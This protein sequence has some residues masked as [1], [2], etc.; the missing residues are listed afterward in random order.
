MKLFTITLMNSAEETAEQLLK[1][2]E[3]CIV[4]LH[5]NL[6]SV[7][8]DKVNLKGCTQITVL[9]VLPL[10]QLGGRTDD[11][12]R[13]AAECVAEMIVKEQE[14]SLMEGLISSKYGFDQA[15][16]QTAIMAY[17]RQMLQGDQ[18]AIGFD[19][20]TIPRRIMK[21]TDALHRYLQEYTDLNVQGFIRFRLPDYIDELREVVEYAIDEYLMDKQYQEFIS[22]LKYFVY[23]QEAKIP[24]AHLIHNGGNEF[25][26]LNDE[27]EPIDTEHV[28]GTVTVEMIEKDINFENMIVS[29]LITVSP[30]KIMI[31]TR[32]PEVQVI[33]TIMQIFEDRTEICGYC[34]LCKSLLGEPK[35]IS[36]ALQ[37]GEQ[38]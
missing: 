27:L 6:D 28:E 19:K 20:S 38:S 17:C 2:I 13:K 9:G 30:Q 32:E 26:L 31:H 24:V 15:E 34:K 10:F 21:L 25:T 33:S 35:A 8:L 37:L 29:T 7:Q 16:E 18:S 1:S 14:L 12:Y 11:I 5:I 22:L 23:I 36:G 3:Q 4:H